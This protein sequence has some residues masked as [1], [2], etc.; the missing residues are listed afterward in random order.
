MS[1]NS[2]PNSLLIP[3]PHSPHRTLHAIL[4]Y[5]PFG[6]MSG[7]YVMDDTQNVTPDIDIVRVGGMYR[8]GKLLGAGTFGMSI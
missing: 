5:F 6:L 3:Q 7:E 4:F 2:E 8:L 1:S